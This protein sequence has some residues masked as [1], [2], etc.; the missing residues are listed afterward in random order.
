MR[1]NVWRIASQG[2]RV[3]RCMS[4]IVEG[5]HVVIR[6]YADCDGGGKPHRF[7]AEDGQHGVVTCDRQPGD[8]SLFVLFKGGGPPRPFG[9]SLP[10]GRCYRP[11][12]LEPML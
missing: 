6:P 1:E 9:V 12:E 7:V 2:R 4:D 8:H 10:L 3:L 11:D 5:S